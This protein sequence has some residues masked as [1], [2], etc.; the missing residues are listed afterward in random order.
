MRTA[1][2]RTPNY[3]RFLVTGAVLGFVI[4][5]V[6]ALWTDT[7]PRYSAGS[8]AA[9]FGVIFAGVGALLAGVVAVLLER[10]P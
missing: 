10:R 8:Q 6:V 5:V 3:L 2:P 7:A 4:G 9:F 1:S